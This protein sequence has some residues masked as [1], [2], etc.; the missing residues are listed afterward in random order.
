MSKPV[1]FRFRGHHSTAP[2]AKNR[3]G[4]VDAVHTQ[5]DQLTGIAAIMFA[6]AWLIAPR[7][8]H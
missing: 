6:R 7:L 8:V 4:L 1:A 2:W 5:S 3:L